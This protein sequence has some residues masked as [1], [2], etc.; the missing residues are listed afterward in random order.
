[1][2][3]TW[4][5]GCSLRLSGLYTAAAQE[6]SCGFDSRTFLC[7]VLGSLQVRQSPRTVQKHTCDLNLGLNGCDCVTLPSAG[8]RCEKIQ[9][10]TVTPSAEEA[11]IEN[12]CMN[13]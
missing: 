10:T 2:G 7:E 1:M 4:S 3:R 5:P 9:Q 6:E 11:G 8:G 13:V 12:E